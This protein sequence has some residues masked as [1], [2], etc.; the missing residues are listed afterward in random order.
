M[1]LKKINRRK[2]YR[3]KQIAELRPVD[4]NDLIQFVRKE[5]IIVNINKDTSIYVSISDADRQSGS[6]K[7]GDMIARNPKNYLDQWLVAEEYFN[8]NFEKV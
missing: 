1:H 2:K 3:R 8:D 5:N 7:Q 4:D 6:P